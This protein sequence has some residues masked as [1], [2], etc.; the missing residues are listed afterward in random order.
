M[1]RRLKSPY[2]DA[3]RN[4]ARLRGDFDVVAALGTAESHDAH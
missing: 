2:Q 4:D 1:V 3:A